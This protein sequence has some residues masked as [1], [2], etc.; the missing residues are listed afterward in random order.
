MVLIDEESSLLPLSS[1]AAEEALEDLAEMAAAAPASA[2]ALEFLLLTAEDIVELD[3]F[4]RRDEGAAGTDDAIG[5]A[6]AAFPATSTS[7]A[8]RLNVRVLSLT[9]IFSCS[10]RLSS[11]SAALSS[12]EVEGAEDVVEEGEASLLSRS[13]VAG[14]CCCCGV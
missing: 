8:I 11:S 6:P 13:A 14:C 7:D 12:A 2:H 3:D 4:R 5:A 9:L 10:L 1:L